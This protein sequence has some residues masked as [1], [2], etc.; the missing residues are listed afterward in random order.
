MNKTFKVKDGNG[1]ENEMM[2]DGYGVA[3]KI[4][5]TN[6]CVEIWRNVDEIHLNYRDGHSAVES[7]IHSVGF[8]MSNDKIQ[9][10]EILYDEKD[11][12][13]ESVETIVKPNYE[14]WIKGV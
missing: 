6:E 2:F 1:V 11:V 4:F 13:K 3:V 7:P 9:S 10:I 5:Y 14:K 8:G 12:A